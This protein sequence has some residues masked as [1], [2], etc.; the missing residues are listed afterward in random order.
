VKI[1]ANAAPHYAVFSIFLSLPPSWVH[2]LFSAS[3]PPLDTKCLAAY[4]KDTRRNTFF[5]SVSLFIFADAYILFYTISFFFN[6][7]SF[8][9]RAP[10][11]CR[12][13]RPPSLRMLKPTVEQYLHS[14]TRRNGVVLSLATALPK[15]LPV[16]NRC[17]WVRFQ[18]LTATSMKMSVFWDVAPCI[19]VDTGRRFRGAYCLHHQGNDTSWGGL[20][21]NVDQLAKLIKAVLYSE[22]EINEDRRFNQPVKWGRF[23]FLLS[24]QLFGNTVLLY[25]SQACHR[26]KLDA[27]SNG[28]NPVYKQ[29]SF[30][31]PRRQ[32]SSKMSFGEPSNFAQ[33]Q[34]LLPLRVITESY[35]S[36]GL[37]LLWDLSF[38]PVLHSIQRAHTACW[39]CV[40]ASLH[41]GV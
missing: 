38:L 21:N 17:V 18:V 39:P 11:R 28:F 8:C 20:L 33:N 4:Y 22:P 14:P 16:N 7:F 24:W 37:I 15:P 9:P 1:T 25:T 19:L 6:S 31:H 32:P 3:P 36:R 12:P 10:H 2:L 27:V 5:P 35:R 40:T 30:Q 34:M 29:T 26:E 13:R 41:G 23:S